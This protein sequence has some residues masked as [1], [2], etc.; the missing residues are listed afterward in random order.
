MRLAEAAFL[1][2][3]LHAKELATDTAMAA[4]RQREEDELYQSL[5]R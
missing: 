2:P 1:C 3:P 4:G 5:V